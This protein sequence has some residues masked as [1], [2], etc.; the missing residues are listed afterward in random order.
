MREVLPVTLQRGHVKIHRSGVFVVVD[1]NLG[2]QIKYDGAHTATVIVS[3]TAK[4]KGLCGNNNGNKGDDLRT[5][6]G[7]AVNATT[8]GWSWRVSDRGSRC[9]AGCEAACPSCSVEQLQEKNVVGQWI[10]LHEYI[11]S[12]RNPL[13]QCQEAVNYTDVMTS[14]SIFDLCSSNAAQKVICQILEAYAAACH[15]A[16]ILVRAWRNSSF[17]RKQIYVCFE[18][19]NTLLF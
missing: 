2:V 13:H 5:P 18:Y 12:P 4:V 10:A 7:E 3:N 1:T 8:F 15:D 17:C 16:H 14:V 19:I 9:T 11:W 6:Q